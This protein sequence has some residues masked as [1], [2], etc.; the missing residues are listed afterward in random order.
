MNNYPHWVITKVFKEIKEITSSEKEVQV[1]E[2]ENTS[3]KNHFLVLAYQ[4]EKGICIV[5]SM[6][7]YVKKILPENVKIETTFTGK[8][9]SSCI[10]TKDRTKFEH[11]ANIIYQ[12]KCSSETCL[13]DYIGGPARHLI[14]RVKDHSGKDTKLHVLKHSSEK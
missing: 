12:V 3:I 10:K 2:A 7:R 9:I 11:Q 6:E 5:N 13:D 8:R 14:E 4:G 1:E